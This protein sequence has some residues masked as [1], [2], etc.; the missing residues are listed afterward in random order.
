M[1]VIDSL[2]AVI[3]LAGSSVVA[4]RGV[5]AWDGALFIK[6]NAFPDALAPVVWGPMQAGALAAPLAAGTALLIRRRPAAAAR[7]AITGSLAW[8]AAKV[9]KRSINRGRPKDHIEST[10]L[11]I[12]SADNGLGYPSGHAAVAVALV[13]ALQ[14]SGP[15]SWRFGGALLV[16]TVGVSR[17]YVG[18][19]YPLDV[20]GGWAL[21]ATIV[22]GYRHA[23]SLVYH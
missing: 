10:R 18:A 1:G 22:D 4:K 15:R 9:V 20:I 8:G 3:V 16:F 6:L 23:E 5:P 7:V 13:S 2:S 17:V 12:G 19:H 14:E 21:G 11:R